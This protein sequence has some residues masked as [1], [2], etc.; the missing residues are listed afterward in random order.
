[1]GDTGEGRCFL[2]PHP[3][4]PPPRAPLRDNSV[5]DEAE[6]FRRRSSPCSH[7]NMS[8]GSTF[9]LTPHSP[10]PPP[11]PHPS[12]PP[13]RGSSSP[14]IWDYRDAAKDGR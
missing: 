10:T 12:Q 5:G 4:G 2:H 3:A 13:P 6:A 1:M 9:T 8:A 14:A 11:P 7:Q